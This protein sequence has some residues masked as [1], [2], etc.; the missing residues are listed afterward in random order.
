VN[1]S[2]LSLFA[3]IQN[4]AATHVPDGIALDVGAHQ[5]EYAKFL[6]SSGMFD[7]VISFEPS[8]II[9]NQLIENV[10]SSDG[11]T[12]RGVN[13]ALSSV[14]GTLDLYTD[15]DSATASLLKYGPNYV[16]KGSISK[17]SVPVVSIDE[18][19]SSYS[20]NKKRLS[21]LKIDTQGNDLAVIK[22]GISSIMRHRPIV[23]TEMIYVPLYDKQ[24]TPGMICSELD[25]MDYHLYSLNNLHVNIEGRLAF[26]DA[27]FVPSELS[28]PNTPTYS[29]IDDQL[30]FEAQLATLSKTCA[31]RLEVINILDREIKRLRSVN[32]SGGGLLKILN[33][34]KSWVQ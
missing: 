27:V 17:Q 5:G 18:Y 19:L 7:E 21:V 6:I 34:V 10:R 2:L 25:N 3:W 22:G 1:T 26:C 9:Y 12:F 33:Q 29:C 31:E 16:T 14:S 11:C 23:Q 8:P 28:I 30:S 15:E 20:D 24:S 13:Q 4:Q 32:V